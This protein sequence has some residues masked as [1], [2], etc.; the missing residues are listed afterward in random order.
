MMCGGVCVY[1]EGGWF[2][3]TLF[4]FQVDV[5]EC[6]LFVVEDGEYSELALGVVQGAFFG[7]WELRVMMVN[8]SGK[9]C[10][11]RVGYGI[12]CEKSAMS[13]M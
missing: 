4:V 7:W 6:M 13:G 12:G 8:W 9:W 11:S 3:D 2:A 5:C 1:E 10:G